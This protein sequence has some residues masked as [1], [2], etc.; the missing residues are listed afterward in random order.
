MGMFWSGHSLDAVVKGNILGQHKLSNVLSKIYREYDITQQK[1]GPIDL[2]SIT[3]DAYWVH[4]KD[5]TRFI[6]LYSLRVFV[7][8]WPESIPNNYHGDE[9]R[10]FLESK[11][12]SGIG[13]GSPVTFVA[14]IQLPIR[15]NE[16]EILF[17][18]LGR[19]FYAS[20]SSVVDRPRAE[21][22]AVKKAESW[23]MQAF[24]KRG[25]LIRLDDEELAMMRHLIANHPELNQLTPLN[26]FRVDE[27]V[28]EEK[29]GQPFDLTV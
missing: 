1:N 6:Y 13:K 10:S 26:I 23:S 7:E 24:L 27:D 19:H 20:G 17:Q 21:R 25:S 3:R 29:E 15:E 12:I 28:F 11:V 2:I 22:K 4:C 8:N 14:P 18:V 5:W 9:Y 16:G